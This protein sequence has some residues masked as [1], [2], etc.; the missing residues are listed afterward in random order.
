MSIL[1]PIIASLRHVEGGGGVKQWEQ[2]PK[3][4]KKEKEKNFPLTAISKMNSPA[5]NTKLHHRTCQ[6]LLAFKGAF[7]KMSPIPLTLDKE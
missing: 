2:L 3:K 7:L 4:K 1:L 6:Q 5:A